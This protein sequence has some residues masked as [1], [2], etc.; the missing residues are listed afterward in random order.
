MTTKLNLNQSPYFDDYDQTK[1]YYQIL[2]R[3]GRAV[4]ARELTQLQTIIQKQI[5][6]LGTNIFKQGD[7]VIPGTNNFISFLRE[8]HFIKVPKNDIMKK[9]NQTTIDNVIAGNW[10]NK[11]ITSTNSDRAGI[12]AKIIGY[13]IDSLDGQEVRFFLTPPTSSSSGA[14]RNYAPGDTIQVQGEPNS[15]T[16]TIPTNQTNVVGLVSSVSVQEGVYFYNGYFVYVEAQQIFLTP[17]I[18][19]GNVDDSS[20]QGK[21]QPAPINM[22]I[23]LEFT[24]SIKT[25]QLNPDLLDNAT[26]TPNQSAPGADRLSIDAKLVQIQ[27]NNPSEEVPENF[28]PLVEIDSLGT[29]IF[30]KN[31]TEYNVVQDTLARRT[32]D[33][34]G[35][36][37]VK[38]FVIHVKNFLIDVENEQDGAHTINEFQF[39]T[40]EAAK[41]YSLEKFK[42]LLTASQIQSGGISIEYPANS[43]VYYPGSS[44]SDPSD[45]TSFKNLCDGFLSLKID[46]GKAYVK[47]YEIEKLGR[48]APIDVPKSRSTTFVN[49]NVLNTSIGSYFNV[50]DLKVW[51]IEPFKKIV[52]IELY[53]DR[54]LHLPTDQSQKNSFKIGEANL[55]SIENTGQ[56]QIQQM[57]LTDIKMFESAKVE[58][59][60]SIFISGASGIQANILLTQFPL[61]GSVSLSSNYTPTTPTTTENN[62]TFTITGV[63]TKWKTNTTEQLK[64]NDVILIT[65]INQYLKVVENPT[66]D[67]QLKVALENGFSGT[68]SAFSGKT[69]SYVYAKLEGDSAPGLLYPLSHEY[70]STIRTQ[71]SDQTISEATD[72]VYIM[73]ELLNTTPAQITGSTSKTA[74]ISFSFGQNLTNDRFDSISNSYKIVDN[75]GNWYTPASGTS[76]PSAANVVNIEFLTGQGSGIKLHFNS[77]IAATS[78][79]VVAPIIRNNKTERTK[80]LTKSFKNIDNTNGEQGKQIL[81]DHYD[82]LRIT[83]IISHNGSNPNSTNE[84]PTNGTDISALYFLDNGQRDF[85]YDKG[86]ITIRSGYN[87]PKTKLYVEYEYFDHSGDG[88]YFS[89][90]SYKG[91]TYGEIPNYTSSLGIPYSLTDSL[92]F[93]KKLNEEANT[94]IPIQRIICDYH[95][96]NSRNDKIV[97]DTKGE[98]R[99]NLGLPELNAQPAKESSDALTICELLH[100]PYGISRESCALKYLDNRRYTMRD[101]GKLEK[102]IKNLEYYTALTLLEKETSELL[103]PDAN[104]NNRFKN[105]FLVDNFS[106]LNSC[107]VFSEDFKCWMDINGEKVAKPLVNVDAVEI[108]DALSENTGLVNTEAEKIT[109]QKALN[110]EEINGVYFLPIKERVIFASQPISSLTVNINPYQVASYVGEIKL[111]PWTDWWKETKELEPIIVKNDEAF[112]N[113]KALIGDGK[114]TYSDPILLGTELSEEKRRKIHWKKGGRELLKAGHSDLEK[115]KKSNPKAYDEAIKNRGK[116]SFRV[117]EGYAN[118][119]QLIPWS[120]GA[121]EYRDLYK[122]T[123]TETTTSIRTG[124]E[125]KIEDLGVS[126]SEALTK[127]EFT[128]IEFIR[129]REI[130]FSGTS[131]SPNSN[132]YAFFDN[133]DVS[134]DC[135]PILFGTAGWS[136]YK[137]LDVY[138]ILAIEPNYTDVSGFTALPVDSK[139]K[140]FKIKTSETDFSRGNAV[141]NVRPGC[142]VVYTTKAGIVKQF[143]VVSISAEGDTKG[144]HIICTQK[145]DLGLISEHSTFLEP[146]DANNSTNQKNGYDI[147]I[148]KH[149]FGDQLKADGSGA[150]A[151]VF[152]IPNTPT[153]RFKTGDVTFGLSSSRVSSS[154]A[155]TSSTTKYTARG[156]LNTQQKTI[157]QTRNFAITAHSLPPIISDTKETVTIGTSWGEPKY[158]DPIAQL[159]KVTEK[160]GCFITDIDIFFAKK[161][162]EG[163]VLLE[164]RASDGNGYPKFE[165]IGGDG[166]KVSAKPNGHIVVNKVTYEAVDEITNQQNK[167]LEIIVD[168]PSYS[169]DVEEEENLQKELLSKIVGPGAAFTTSSDTNTTKIIWNKDSSVKPQ[170]IILDS[171]KSIEAIVSE[172]KK[173]ATATYSNQ[174]FSPLMVP[175]RFTFDAPLYLEENKEYVLVLL[176]D[177]TEYEVWATQASSYKT[178]SGN[179]T[180]ANISEYKYYSGIGDPIIKIGTTES[181]DSQSLYGMFFASR[182]GKTWTAHQTTSLRY[183]LLKAKFDISQGGTINFVNTKTEEVAI[184]SVMV[185]KDIKK[186][187]IF[188]KNHGFAVDDKIKLFVNTD[189]AGLLGIP[190]KLFNQPLT[191][192]RTEIDEVVVDYSSSEHGAPTSSGRLA[193]GG[194][195]TAQ[196][197][198]RFEQA[199]L[200]TT[201]FLPNDETSIEYSIETTP[202]KGVHQFTSDGGEIELLNTKI[203]AISM[204]PSIPFEFD[205]SMKINCES[206]EPSVSINL[207]LQNTSK[208]EQL[209][210]K[211]SLVVKAVLRSEN[212]NLSPVLDPERIGVSILSTRL[213]NPSGKNNNNSPIKKDIQTVINDEFDDLIVLGAGALGVSA[214]GITTTTGSLDISK[215]LFFSKS[216][217]P[218]PGRFTQDDN[219]TTIKIDT[220]LC[221]ATTISN[222]STSTLID[223]ASLALA[224]GSGASTLTLK[225]GDKVLVKEQST[226]S[227]NGIYV[228]KDSGAP[229]KLVTADYSDIFIIVSNSTQKGTYTIATTGAVTNQSTFNI[230]SYL[231]IGDKVIDKNVG[232][233]YQRTVVEF[234]DEF[235]FK[236]DSPFNPALQPTTIIGGTIIPK[237]LYT[238]SKY[239]EITTTNFE[240]AKLLSQLD[241]GKYASLQLQTKGGTTLTDVTSTIEFDKKLILGVEYTPS[242]ATSENKIKIIIEHNN[243]D[244]SSGASK[245]AYDYSGA[246]GTTNAI[247]T[248]TQLDKFVEEIAPTGGSAASKY[249]SKRLILDQLC[250]A[251]KISFDAARDESCNI[252]L[253]YRTQ[254]S[255]G[256]SASQK[257]WIKADFNIEVNGILQNKT[258]EPNP[259]SFASYESTLNNL[260]SFDGVEVKIVMLGGNPAK[261][262][263]IKNLKVI[264]LDE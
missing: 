88:H 41:N 100:K 206:S 185:K 16:A 248:L 104:G 197:N 50:T 107:D 121:S 14:S 177:S 131:F 255:N 147:K 31:K 110:Y 242:A 18:T 175:T 261:A 237:R 105:G 189:A 126:E 250:N 139:T 22:K 153:R 57:Y 254:Q 63:G 231:N 228:I 207:N 83:K 251:L 235:T 17:N 233:N 115:L 116:N 176:T 129:S 166:G 165:L 113:A 240:L 92:D 9:Y 257:N 36:Y 179:K 200:Y 210:A 239:M 98:F 32:Y 93:R 24:E 128:E 48:S 35:D 10:L 229:T 74:T 82:I 66:S 227:D 132:L 158:R 99:L 160:G 73:P 187:R 15:N 246:S 252:V 25:Y 183:N 123:A 97:L 61:S 163:Q 34:S 152:K 109:A 172:D 81:L 155:D 201:S 2:F 143:E 170:A 232:N 53:K 111:R 75:N 78:V 71:N 76:A 156:I 94:G 238:D 161:P 205:S 27:S 39:T 108:I 217:A 29:V 171:N 162:K 260:P 204:L 62:R 253:Y 103:I 241:V 67:T 86:I 181:V 135:R 141:G 159:F 47:G 193:L 145:N 190:R 84:A 8:N 37:V 44:F 133:I 203:D 211:K 65:G 157:T 167:K 146:D 225:A 169:S 42:H 85:Y 182:N 68:I 245:S 45:K 112:N 38:D 194:T 216:E 192:S 168:I 54:L 195:I 1:G 209:L 244:T 247:V 256:V 64:K 120:W 213:D 142:E 80:Q 91:I 258:P 114:I 21:W 214:D 134:Q 262:P 77:S 43:E 26:G 46:P 33:E 56:S 199:T 174:D 137:I 72:M 118:A 5:E 102:R 223:G 230:A 138:S 55:I 212:E 151:G 122:H 220:F 234:I 106:S 219:S 13:R 198:K 20:N 125:E 4:Q 49:N 188:A 184:T 149:T 101:I 19:D 52:K 70:V 178:I 140:I 221:D 60:K 148:S 40:R 144:S 7:N 264:A 51:S 12:S 96:Y 154:S 117:P 79:S 236:V 173:T 180:D 208:L 58:E 191:I 127:N 87:P 30:R 6:R 130:K 259:Y 164:L 215:N 249:I 224:P 243:I 90:D 150:V 119:G 28:V 226:T 69:I 89:V 222:I 95:F 124:F 136:T 202:T 59:I 196:I 23:G 186:L 263:K 218:L 11:T 3:P